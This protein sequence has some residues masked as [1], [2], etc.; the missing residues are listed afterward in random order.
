[1]SIGVIAIKPLPSNG[2]CFISHCI[3]VVIVLLLNFGRCL[4][5]GLDV[6]TDMVYTMKGLKEFGNHWESL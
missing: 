6:T 5:R 1:V 4:A 2:R 3:T